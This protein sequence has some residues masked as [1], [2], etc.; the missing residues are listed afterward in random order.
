MLFTFLIG[1]LAFWC[2]TC[3]GQWSTSDWD[4]GI[5]KSSFLTVPS[6]TVYFP[7]Q[8]IRPIC[9]SQNPNSN[10]R[11][12]SVSPYEN[13]KACIAVLYLDDFGIPLLSAFSIQKSKENKVE[14]YRAT[15]AVFQ[16]SLW[17][18]ILA[19]W[20]Y[21]AHDAQDAPQS[22]N[23]DDW[24]TK[25]HY[26]R[27]HL[28]PVCLATFISQSMGTATFNMFNIAPQHFS[29]NK[30]QSDYETEMVRF[31]TDYCFS[32]SKKFLDKDVIRDFYFVSGTLPDINSRG[33][34]MGR[35]RRTPN[36]DTGNW[37]KDIDRSTGNYLFQYPSTFPTK[38]FSNVPGLFWSAACCMYKF[39]IGDY[40]T[41]TTSYYIEN[42]E[43][44]KDST[45]ILENFKWLI[46]N[47]GRKYNSHVEVEH[48][49]GSTACEKVYQYGE[50]ESILRR[51]KKQRNVQSL[52]DSLSPSFTNLVTS[53]PDK[54]LE[55]A[56]K[57]P[58]TN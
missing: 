35:R 36:I 25:R 2:S 22:W 1:Y 57:R 26:N 7:A 20:N 16:N 53:F 45:G 24:F 58:R 29:T 17:N 28:V 41:V 54:P 38:E 13:S 34:R 23:R 14:K 44:N 27:G 3:E 8:R 21:N 51:Y 9:I 4:F 5:C 33:L 12:S 48:L 42:V 30:K 11:C 46:N 31:V 19:Y 6:I 47:K 39:P 18:N 49:F 43:N 37:I 32:E 10:R 52:M 40:F 15:R 55:P 56:R 50:I